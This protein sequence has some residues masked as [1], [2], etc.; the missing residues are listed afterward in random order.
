LGAIID[1]LVGQHRRIDPLLESG[2]RAFAGLPAGSSD[3]VA[4]EV[5]DERGVAHGRPGFARSLI[6]RRARLNTID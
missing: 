2:D 3:G 1:E 6:H 5:T 4:P